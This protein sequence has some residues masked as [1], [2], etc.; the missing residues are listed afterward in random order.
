MTTKRNR[1]KP[2]DYVAVPASQKGNKLAAS[3]TV[4][5]AC[6]HCLFLRN[7]G[8]ALAMPAL[9]ADSI[10]LPKN[11][12]IAIAG[13][14]SE[15][16]KGAYEKE[17]GALERFQVFDSKTLCPANRKPIKYKWVWKC[18]PRPKGFIK[19]WKARLVIVGCLQCQYLDYN[20]T[21]APTREIVN[22]PHPTGHS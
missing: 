15:Q 9:L 3:A 21:F 20:S 13:F 6:L 19:T 2:V 7:E 22:Y 17:S 14:Y 16:W 10:I 1:K 8:I 11:Y 18:K 4:L 5:C 12:E